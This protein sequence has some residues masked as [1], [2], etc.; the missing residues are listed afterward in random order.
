MTARTRVA[1]EIWNWMYGTHHNFET[2]G[3]KADRL[4]RKGAEEEEEDPPEED[5]IGGDVETFFPML[6]IQGDAH[7]GILCL[8]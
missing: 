5:Q 6:T 4:P 2:I 8:I 7:F 3:F 1:T